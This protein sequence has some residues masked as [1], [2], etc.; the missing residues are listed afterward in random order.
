[1]GL[2]REGGRERFHIDEVAAIGVRL[3]LA[4]VR[5]IGI[6]VFLFAFILR[7]EASEADH[8]RA[9]RKVFDRDSRPSRLLG[10]DEA[11][12]ACRGARWSDRLRASR[13]RKA[14]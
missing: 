8:R 6:N 11:E 4:F 9:L 14:S 12:T 13:D 7:P 1:M 3:L 10:K 5:S 2:A